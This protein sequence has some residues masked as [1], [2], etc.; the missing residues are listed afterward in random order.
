MADST[1]VL[2]R[3]DGGGN[4]GEPP[5]QTRRLPAR[6]PAC[7]AGRSV[8][9]V[10]EQHLESLVLISDGGDMQALCRPPSQPEELL[11]TRAPEY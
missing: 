4:E 6:L 1:V 9:P 5:T 8:L 10:A 11:K 3:M 7:L 2:S